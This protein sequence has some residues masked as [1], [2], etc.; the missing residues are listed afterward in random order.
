MRVPRF[1][2]DD[3][4]QPIASLLPILPL[5]PGFKGEDSCGIR[6]NSEGN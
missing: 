2:I 1:A 4:D 6:N 5:S 3:L